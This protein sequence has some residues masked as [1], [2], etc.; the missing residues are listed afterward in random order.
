MSITQFTNIDASTARV[1]VVAA[2]PTAPA[3]YYGVTAADET[4]VIEWKGGELAYLS[5]TSKLYVQTAT[6]GQTATWRYLNDTFA[7]TSSTSTSTSTSTTSSTSSTSTSTS[8]STSSSTSTSTSTS[9]TT[10][11]A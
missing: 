4:D 2:V 5:T 1:K 7:T 9:S 3:T 10:T 8:T 6:S 11:A